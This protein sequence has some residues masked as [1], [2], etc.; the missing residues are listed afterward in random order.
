MATVSV[1]SIFTRGARS[2]DT[3]EMRQTR[4]LND[5][6]R[7]NDVWTTGFPGGWR[8]NIQFTSRSIIFRDDVT[9]NANTVAS[10]EDQRIINLITDA[11]QATNNAVAIYVVYLPGNALIGGVSNANGGPYFT[12]FNN[13]NDYGLLGRVIMTD[14]TVDSYILAHESGHVLFGRFVGGING[15]TILDPSDLGGFGHNN[16]PQNVMFSSTPS[17]SPLINQAQC[18]VASQ[19]RV[20]LEN[21]QMNNAMGGGLAASNIAA[22]GAAGGNATNAMPSIGSCSCCSHHHPESKEVRKLNRVLDNEIKNYGPCDIQITP[23]PKKKCK[24]KHH[25]KSTRR[26]RIR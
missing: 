22:G 19:S 23:I 12:F 14:S 7:C 9:I 25:Y 10:V 17:Q 3:A 2:S 21:V 5:I 16:N 20:I 1:V 18:N 8:C 13:V 4:A 11:R 6:A 24:H 15:L 26:I